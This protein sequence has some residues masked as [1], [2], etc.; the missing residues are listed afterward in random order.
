MTFLNDLERDLIGQ[1][2]G[3]GVFAGGVFEQ[4]CVIEGGFLNKGER[5][6]EIG[7]CLAWEP[8]DDIG[9]DP[10]GRGGLA[11]F[12][13]DIEEAFARVAAVHESEDPIATAL[14]GEMCV[15]AE[16]GQASEGLDEIISVA[17]GMR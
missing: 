12:A 8:D 16:L 10:D 6:V 13:N 17:F 14:D 4:V 15:F 1:G 5:G 9:A 3:R 11:E 7:F 2:C